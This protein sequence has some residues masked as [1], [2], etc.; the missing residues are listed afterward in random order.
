VI[1]RFRAAP[2]ISSPAA[3]QVKHTAGDVEG[4]VARRRRR[5]CRSSFAVVTQH[6]AV[7]DDRAGGAPGTMNHPA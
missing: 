2:G 3:G 1:Y 7:A 6:D 5:C 4:L